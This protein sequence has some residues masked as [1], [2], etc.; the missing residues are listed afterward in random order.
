MAL[1]SEPDSPA[2]LLRGGTV[3]D[4]SGAPRYD[5]I[6][7]ILITWSTPHPEMAARSLAGIAAEWGCTQQEACE[8]L[9]PGGACYFQMREDDVQRVLRHPA[10]MIGSDGL[11][12]DQHPHPRLWG[13]F[14]RVLGH[15]SRDLGLFPL[16]T[17]VHKMTGLSARQF[18]LVDRGE[19]RVG[20]WADLV[21]FDAAAIGD[22]A[23]FERPKAPAAGVECVLVNGHVAYTHGDEAPGRHGR[24]LARAT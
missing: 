7:D 16:E 23:T 12:H 5:G 2:L 3:F 1:G 9:Q 24:F 4:G 10:T 20:A 21:V 14:P 11:P 15:Y 17:A 22:T 18:G 13:T 8:R 19:I 6:T